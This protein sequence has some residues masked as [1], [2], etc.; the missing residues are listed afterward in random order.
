MPRP[1]REE[2][3]FQDLSSDRQANI[4]IVSSAYASVF[5]DKAYLTM[6]VTTGRRYY[7]VLDR[8]GVKTVAELEQKLPGALRNEIILPNI[9]EGMIL[10]AKIQCEQ[11][12]D[13]L[14]VPGVFEARKQR[15]S[16]EEYMVLWLR[17]I[18]DSA[19]SLYLTE[20]WE[21]SNGGAI[22]FTRALAKQYRF[23]GTLT[24]FD[25]WSIRA[26]VIYDHAGNEVEVVG[27]AAK[28]VEAICDLTTR[29]FDTATLRR[30]LGLI[31]GLTWYM[32]DLCRNASH[33]N[34]VCDLLD[35]VGVE[36]SLELAL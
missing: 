28:L 25:S 14:V 19:Q 33:A 11:N 16:Q 21:Y 24:H 6:P 26:M 31:G 27:A 8:Y 32:A 23:V 22:E 34:K 3:W 2:Q 1:T 12:E 4:E 9:E 18:T 7:D 5:A 15:W 36:T 29:G 13:A 20:G 35:S 10:A 17:F 30:E